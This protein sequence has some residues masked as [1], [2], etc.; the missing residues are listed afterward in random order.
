[1]TVNLNNIGPFKFEGE[2]KVICLLIHG[3]TSAPSDMRALGL[4]LKEKGF[5]VSCPL[6]PGHGTTPE[7][8]K[9]TTWYDWYQAV[10]D[11]YLDLQKR[12][13]ESYIIPVG[14]SMGG[15][16][17][18]HLAANH[19]VKALVTVCAAIFP[20]KKK[21]YFA[22]IL[23]YV[24]EYDVKKKKTDQKEK[25]DNEYFAYDK[26]PVRAANSLLSLMRIVKKELNK[27]KASILI[28]Q[29]TNDKTVEPQSA[30][31]IYEKVGSSDKKIYWLE[32][33]GH[34]ATL[35]VES[36]LVFQL[37]TDFIKKIR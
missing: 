26:I 4:Y 23:R 31:F 36:D 11:E 1:M 34:V 7:E 9:N 8:M 5:G 37:V 3:F 2:K 17:A 21:L 6:L 12:Y 14:L 33:S 35:G 25:V 10:E 15:L 16:L 28:L 27:I 24:L 19:N 20:R 22:P 29:A 13:Q 32:K 30:R 18:L